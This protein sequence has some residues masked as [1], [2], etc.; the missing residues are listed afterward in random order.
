MLK[1]L[2][3]AL[4]FALASA[5][6]ATTLSPIQLLNPVGSTSGQAIVSTGPSTPPNWVAVLGIAGGTLTGPLTV[7]SLTVTSSV[8]LPA[9][10]VSLTALSN[11]NANSLVG[12][13]STAGATASVAVP[14]CDATGYALMWNPGVGFACNMAV[15]AATL[16][17]YAV[18]TSGSAIA[19]LQNG[20]TWGAAQTFPGVSTTTLSASSTVSGTGFT[21]Y[22]ASPPA[23]GGTTAAAGSFTNLSSSGTVSGTGFTNYLAS[24]P[25]IGGTAAAAGKFTTLTATSTVTGFTGRL[26]NVQVFTASGTY[27]PTTGTTSAIVVVQAPGGGSAGAPATSTG[28]SASSSGGGAGS[29]AKVYYTSV[30]SQTITIGAVGTGGAAGANNGGAGGTTSFGSIVSC[31]GG[32]GGNAGAAVSAAG[33]TGA[34]S[35]VAAC[36]IS[37]ATTIESVAGNGSGPGMV[38]TAGTMSVGSMGGSSPLGTGGAMRA[39]SGT[40]LS[41]TGY[42]SG[43]GGANNLASASAAAGANSQPGLIEVY[44]FSN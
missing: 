20:N 42:G 10:S 41:G 9:N 19:A 3:A 40:G 26:L 6:Q 4:L 23:I 36:T 2:T 13:T 14:S 30:A 22:L 15:N 38:M 33:P 11:P 27:T 43:A 31:P 37:G 39:G 7:P 24:P 18:G 34:A 12:N 21:N 8:S 5:A 25:A 32:A 35:G 1:K 28:Q 44:E 17:G 29:Y 16:N